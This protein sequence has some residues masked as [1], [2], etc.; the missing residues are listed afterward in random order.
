M[1]RTLNIAHSNHTQKAVWE[2]TL[3][4]IFTSG[5]DLF[6]ANTDRHILSFGRVVELRRAD[7]LKTRGQNTQEL[8]IR[9]DSDPDL[10]GPTLVRRRR[11]DR[12]HGS[13]PTT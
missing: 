2:T 9:I 3:V 7:P 6:S 8:R 12:L 4:P 11:P 13:G 10:H 1:E 5:N